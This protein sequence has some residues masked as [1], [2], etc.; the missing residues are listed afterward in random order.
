MVADFVNTIF[1]V[2]TV[3]VHYGSIVGK[4]S[5]EGVF[6]HNV[7]SMCMMVQ[8][9]SN[10]ASIMVLTRYYKN[11]QKSNYFLGIY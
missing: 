9:C 2:F 3:Y 4:T 6:V 10:L 5:D 1:R 11:H 8:V 7:K